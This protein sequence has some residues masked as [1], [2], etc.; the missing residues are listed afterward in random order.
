MSATVM[1]VLDITIVNVALPHIQ[2]A[3]TASTDQISWVL[4]S[5]LV[6]S[7][8]VMPLTG[9]FSDRVGQKRY[10]MASVAGF[11]CASALCGLSTSI[12]EIVAF[13]LLQGVFGAA[14]VPLSQSIMVQTYPPEE[15]GRAM[16]IW[17]MGVMVGPILGPTL[18]GYLT[19][20]LSWRWTFYI[21]VPVGLLSLL[22]AWRVVPDTQRRER[23]MDWLGLSLLALA[24]GG[25]QFVLDQGERSDWFNSHLILLASFVAGIAFLSFLA[26]AWRY[27][28]R[29]VFKLRIFLDRNFT[30]STLLITIIGLGLYGSLL[31]QP[32]MLQHLMDYPVLTTGLVMAPRGVASMA[33][34]MLVGRLSRRVDARAMIIV[35]IALAAADS[36]AMTHYSLVIDRSWII[37]PL[38]LQGL[39]MGF[40]FV[41]LSTVAY[42]TLRVEDAADAAGLFSLLRTI[43]SSIGISAVST[44]LARYAQISWN[45][46]GGHVST[47]NP[48]LAD[49][50][51]QL[52]LGLQQ[53]QAA[54]VLGSVLGR[55]ASMLAFLDSYMLVTWS[56]LAM[57]PLLVF[58]GSASTAA[59]PEPAAEA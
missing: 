30:T 46:L 8:I 34:M 21:N 50:L 18:G 47:T 59:H 45:Q 56:F 29:A 22:L 2:R 25:L 5:Y 28:Q 32:L 20:V 40:I 27:P 17:G 33:S 41:P 43:G 36:Y 58:M 26:Y 54:A 7:A 4:T 55:Q 35:G 42:A 31:L 23:R 12:T 10:L 6:S 16:A 44:I 48:A 14:L 11:V 39:G 51:G 19:Q 1:Q 57:L 49:Y 24:I 38:V 3:L 53:P 37:W 13:R 15:R 9:Y 52:H